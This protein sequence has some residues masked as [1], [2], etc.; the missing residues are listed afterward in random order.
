MHK[1]GMKL[2]T[3]LLAKMTRTNSFDGE[4]PGHILL[5]DCFTYNGVK[6]SLTIALDTDITDETE[7]DIADDPTDDDESRYYDWCL[8]LTPDC[9]PEGYNIDLQDVGSNKSVSDL[10]NKLV[11]AYDWYKVHRR[12]DSV[13]VK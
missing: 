3:A 2:N 9:S 13:K 11:A 10:Y 1:P 4:Y 5:L 6:W 8:Q 7:F 12:K